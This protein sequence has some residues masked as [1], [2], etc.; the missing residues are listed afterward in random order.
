MGAVHSLHSLSP[1]RACDG[2]AAHCCKQSLQPCDTC[3]LQLIDRLV[4]YL[5]PRMQTPQLYVLP[6]PA[7]VTVTG[8][9][10]GQQAMHYDC[11]APQRHRGA[12]QWAAV[13][14]ASRCLASPYQASPWSLQVPYL[15]M[16]TTTWHVMWCSCNHTQT[17]SS[18]RM[19]DRHV[20]WLADTATEAA[21]AATKRRLLGA[22]SQAERRATSLAKKVKLVSEAVGQDFTTPEGRHC[23]ACHC[24]SPSCMA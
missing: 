13:V 17:S 5:A 16:S 18:Q 1:A 11:V 4:L 14:A 23:R 12:P 3:P 2:L 15:L 20:M 21:A 19:S 22:V 8:E 24:L 6:N 9:Y 7:G 10:V